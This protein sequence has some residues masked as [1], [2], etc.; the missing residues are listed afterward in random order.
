MP[1]MGS[2]SIRTCRGNGEPE[3]DVDVSRS[4]DRGHQSLAWMKLRTTG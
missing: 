4:V 2:R 1:L 3:D